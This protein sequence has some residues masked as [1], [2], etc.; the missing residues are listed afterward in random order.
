MPAG[1]DNGYYVQP[2][3]P[4]NGDTTYVP[5]LSY[6]NISRSSVV[7][8]DFFHTYP[9]SIFAYEGFGS[10]AVWLQYWAY[11]KTSKQ[12]DNQ[13]Y[14]LQTASLPNA[15]KSGT[16]SW[17]YGTDIDSGKRSELL[18]NATRQVNSKVLNG[19]PSWDVL[20]DAVEIGETTS[21]LKDAGRFLLQFSKGVASRNPKAILRA[22]GYKPTV[23]RVRRMSKKLDS[24]PSAA[25]HY[26]VM[27]SLWMSYRYGVTP[28]LYSI[29]DAIKV[30]STG[31]WTSDAKTVYHGFSRNSWGRTVDKGW[32]GAI[33]RKSS[34]TYS[35][36]GSAHAIAYVSYVSGLKAKLIQNPAVALLR[37]SWEEVP[38]S[39]VVDWFYDI[40]TWINSLNLGSITTS[41]SW[42]CLSER[43]QSTEVAQI[44][45]LSPSSELYRIQLIGSTGTRVSATCNWFNRSKSSLSSVPPTLSWGVSN[46]KRSVDSLVLSVS[47]VRRMR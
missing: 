23:R 25:S 22:F 11:N 37:T 30:F 45:S 20:T 34:L 18:T 10:A 12:W 47:R 40:G 2:L 4:L 3:L 39:F 43:A 17:P 31:N 5:V 7:K 44:E 27:S 38:F 24:F 32:S 9:Y 28:L 21:L 19:F 33:V 13:G 14:M 35:R 16:A 26:D 15:G 46:F 8:G 36:T 29:G 1:F 42:V 6:R 41:D